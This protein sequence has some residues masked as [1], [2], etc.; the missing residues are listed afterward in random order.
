M[1]G[2]DLLDSFHKA[3]Y[4]RLAPELD[5]RKEALAHGSAKVR[6]NDTSTV[7]EKYA[8]AVAYIMALEH[9][10]EVCRELEQDRYGTRPLDRED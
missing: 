9:V 1:S 8:A 7:A 2:P 3:L 5:E 4:N 6:E 10:L